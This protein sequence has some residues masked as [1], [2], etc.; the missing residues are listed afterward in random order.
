MKMRII[1]MMI[2]IMIMKI[3]MRIIMRMRLSSI[4]IEAIGTAFI[5]YEKILS[6]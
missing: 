3:I 1:I 4:V 6:I 5:F 2:M